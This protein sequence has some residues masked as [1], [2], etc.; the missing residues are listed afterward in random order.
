MS[1]RTNMA[2][3]PRIV[4]LI[5]LVAS[6]CGHSSKGTDMSHSDAE[7]LW[8][9]SREV[10]AP[11]TEGHSLADTYTFNYQG[12]LVT[13]HL[14]TMSKVS[15][16]SP[17]DFYTLKSR[18]QG[19]TLQYLTPVGQWIDLATFEGGQFVASGDGKRREYARI[20]PDQIAGFSAGILKPDRPA[21]DYS[22]SMK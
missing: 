11:G 4:C 21:F 6:A 22:R 12:G 7:G 15:W 10:P 14:M 9:Q 13:L 5:L 8:Q 1:R 16:R 19:D 18:W 20:M 17:D 2:A 3:W